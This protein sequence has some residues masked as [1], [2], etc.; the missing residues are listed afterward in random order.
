MLKL[1][2]IA[3][4]QEIGIILRD[5]PFLLTKTFS[6]AFG[7]ALFIHL[8][9]FTIFHISPFKIGYSES[10][11]PPAI[12]AA[13]LPFRG[14]GNNLSIQLM[15]EAIPSYLIAPTI[16]I[17]E[18][19]LQLQ[20][21]AIPG[22]FSLHP[23]LSL[24]DNVGIQQTDTLFQKSGPKLPV[25]I[26][27]SAG[28]ANK[29]YDNN[30]ELLKIITEPISSITS[31]QSFLFTVQIEQR[32]GQIFWWEEKTIHASKDAHQQ[33]IKILKNLRFD[34]DQEGFVEL[35]NVEIIFYPTNSLKKD[36]Q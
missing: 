27:L 1:E 6:L 13:D 30:E 8:G 19:S 5:K 25:K 26:H 17:P 14:N 35:G 3:K 2:K 22:G 7:C 9:A 28:L 32:T 12:V 33:A 4:T 23:F 24:E 36:F 11:F 31:E 10:I 29:A 21:N 20:E 15:E 18:L 16:P 34:T